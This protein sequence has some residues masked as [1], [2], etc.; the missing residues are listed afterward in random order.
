LFVFSSIPPLLVL[1][2]S[3][4][5]HCCVTFLS[6]VEAVCFCFCLH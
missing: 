2:P 1:L 6:T 4:S 5:M 3:Y